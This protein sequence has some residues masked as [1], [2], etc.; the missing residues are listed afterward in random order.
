M[1][2]WRGALEYARRRKCEADHALYYFLARRTLLSWHRKLKSVLKRRKYEKLENYLLQKNA[3]LLT[4]CFDH[5]R[6]RV[7]ALRELGM[8][9]VDFRM[10]K[11]AGI[12]EE[13]FSRW[14]DTK[15]LFEDWKA[16]SVDFDRRKKIK[17]DS[18]YRCSLLVR[19]HLI[20][21]RAVCSEIRQLQDV[22]GDHLFLR[23]HVLLAQHLRA[24]RMRLLQL[25][26]PQ[27][28]ALL[29]IQR[30]QRLQLR[31]MLRLWKNKLRI[32][33]EIQDSSVLSDRAHTA[34][35]T[36]TRSTRRLI[37]GSLHSR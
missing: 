5:W 26:G 24:W 6:N 27:M 8:K 16:H 2:K 23:N 22:A 32:K 36:P 18:Y 25:K 1:T 30:S 13:A 10:E 33:R 37:W 9:A 14:Q 21:W 15:R 35:I 3:N 31:L 4:E 7:A 17:C 20:R 28:Q 11:E 29:F 12:L 34:P 19:E